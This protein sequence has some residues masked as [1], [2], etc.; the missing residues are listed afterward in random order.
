[1][2]AV[3]A[4]LAEFAPTG[5]LIVTAGSRLPAR[6]RYDAAYVVLAGR[7]DL[8]LMTADQRLAQTPNLPCAVE[9]F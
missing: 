9:A 4:R 1:M 8:P 7:L 5:R 3:V 2:R 6:R